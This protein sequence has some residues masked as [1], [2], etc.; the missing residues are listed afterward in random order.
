MTSSVDLE[1]FPRP[2]VTVDL[3][4]LTVVGATDSLPELRLLVQDR[5]DPV[6]RALPGGFIRE[7]HTVAQ[8]AAEILRRKV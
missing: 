1:K 7:R 5:T 3:A 2:G 4:I 8:T 6:G